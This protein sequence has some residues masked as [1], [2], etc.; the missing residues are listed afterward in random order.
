MGLFTNKTEDNSKEAPAKK[1]V[2]KSDKVAKSKK[3]TVKKA[4]SPFA[5]V[6]LGPVVTEKSYTLADMGK[7]V[8][9]V[10]PDATKRH[11]ARAVADIFG[12]TVDNVNIVRKGQ[13]QKK[14]RGRVGMTKIQKKAIVTV[15]KGEKIDL[16]G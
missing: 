1:A 12:V 4:P 14:F 9:R 6:L 13:Q 16:F 5:H 7:Y 10:R 2:S 11:I 3:K 15:A 8:F